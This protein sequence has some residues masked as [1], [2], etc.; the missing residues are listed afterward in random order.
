MTTRVIYAAL[1]LSTHPVAPCRT[2]DAPKRTQVSQAALL[3]TCVITSS[4]CATGAAGR[5]PAVP[6]VT[7]AA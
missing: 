6:K 5:I 1:L 7:M 3:S 2:L 4:H